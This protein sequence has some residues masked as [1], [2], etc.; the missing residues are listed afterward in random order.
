MGAA[1]SLGS[2][3]CAALS[4]RAARGWGT[5][6][7]RVAGSPRGRGCAG[8]AQPLVIALAT[9]AAVLVVV[10]GFETSASRPLF[11]PRATAAWGWNRPEAMRPASTPSAYLNQLADAASEWFDARPADPPGLAR[12]IGELRQGCSALILA[13]HSPLSAADRAWLVE[14]CRAWAAKF[15]AERLAIE[16]GR[17]PA[18]VRAEVDETV[19]R[20]VR[21]VRDRAQATA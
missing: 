10:A 6:Q 9:A 12:R 16:A 21:R 19:R 7:F 8:R 4:I 1:G 20:L 17:D 3:R 18:S 13:E 15:D 11:G 2:R 5:R 14:K